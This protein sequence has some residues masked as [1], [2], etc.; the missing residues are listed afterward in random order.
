MN[1]SLAVAA[2]PHLPC[3][4]SSQLQSLNEIVRGLAKAGQIREDEVFPFETIFLG[5]VVKFTSRSYTPHHAGLFIFVSSCGGNFKGD[6]KG[7]T[8]LHATIGSATPTTINLP[9]GY[10]ID[11]AKL[12][13][14]G[15]SRSFASETFS[16]K[17]VR[18]GP[19]SCM[20]IG[21]GHEQSCQ[22]WSP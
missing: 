3:P 12:S 18:L 10:S 20:W 22:W 9:P 21:F 13:V 14:P 6:Q 8:L 17:E 5:T 2:G 4:P 7:H 11:T 19:C 15:F 1:E 16:E